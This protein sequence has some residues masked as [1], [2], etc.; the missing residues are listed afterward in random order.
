MNKKEN[1]KSNRKLVFHRV[2]NELLRTLKKEKQRLMAELK[3]QQVQSQG[4]PTTGNHMADDA[5][6]VAEQAKAMALRNNLEAML[7]QVDRALAH[8]AK[9]TY[10]LCERCGKP[11]GAERLKVMPWAT[12]CIEHAKLSQAPRLKVAA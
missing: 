12:L 7:K 8:I 11:I 2:D 1:K 6:D 9:R 5:T 10:G 4:H 3:R